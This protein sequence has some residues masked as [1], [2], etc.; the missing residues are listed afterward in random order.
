MTPATEL[1]ARLVNGSTRLLGIIGHPIAQVK[2]PEV[3]SAMFRHHGIN[4][5]CVPMHVLPDGLDDFFAG[6]RRI[7]NLAGLVVTIPHK[8]PVL[9]YMDALTDRA[10]KVGSVNIIIFGPDG[11]LTGDITDGVGCV[12]S[13]IAGGG[14]PR[15]KRALQ[16]GTGG[17]GSAIAFALADGGVS[18]LVV[19]DRDLARAED[20]A[21][22]VTAAGTPSRVGSPDPTGFE[23]VV[24]ASP[25]GMREGD[26]LPVEAEKL[27]PGTIVMDVIV[28][29]TRLLE[30][31]DQR[32]CKTFMG[33]GMMVHQL[34]AQATML[35]FGAYDFSPETSARIARS[36][37]S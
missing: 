20:V 34:Q 23:V 32:G 22:R 30:I 26:P 6:A 4:M 36:I 25:A 18:E 24:N 12:N 1:G 35:G 31:A 11:K 17:V 29:R 16:I 7:K 33:T 19:Y 14:D 28:E 15:G 27:A 9:K 3:W 37:E 5:L 2:A 21:R 13:M 8:P 10:R